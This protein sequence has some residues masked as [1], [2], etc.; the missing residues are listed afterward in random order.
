MRVA[1]IG[2]DPLLALRRRA[3]VELDHV[4]VV[5]IPDAD[6][7]SAADVGGIDVLFIGVARSDRFE[8]AARAARAGTNVFIEWPPAT[9][10][11]ECAALVRLAEES[12]VECGVSRPLRFAPILEPMGGGFR[13]QAVSLSFGGGV[14]GSHVAGSSVARTGDA[15]SRDIGSGQAGSHDAGSHDAGSHAAGSLS[16]AA[17][18]PEYPDMTRL[19]ADAVDLSCALVKSSSVRRIDAEVVRND[20]AHPEA[21]LFSLRF[22]SSAYAQAV[23][24]M[25]RAGDDAYVYAADGRMRVEGRLTAGDEAVRRETEAFLEALRRGLPAPVSALDAL[26]TMR[27]LER[28]Q[29]VL[30]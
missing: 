18:G 6:S 27:I 10:I 7:A 28:L 30:R 9:S 24:R 25:H 22:H 1:T 14:D 2:S 17:T 29:G 15:G 23:V 11:R 12:G 4:E 26:Y 21:T 13:A 3:L 5:A 8:V 20:N 16:S 19:L